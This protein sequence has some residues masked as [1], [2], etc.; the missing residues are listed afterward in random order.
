MN[1]LILAW[2]IQATGQLVAVKLV[3]RRRMDEG[4]EELLRLEVSLLKELQHPHI[5]QLLDFV[6]DTD[7]FH[8]VLELCAG[9]EVFDKIVEKVGK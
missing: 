4:E 5:I 7:R 9:G 6:E 3:E 2:V 1:P 8:L